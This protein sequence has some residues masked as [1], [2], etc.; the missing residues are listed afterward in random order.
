MKM[1]FNE[2]LSWEK[3]KINFHTSH[4]ALPHPCYLTHLW[5]SA[6][7]H[8]NHFSS[9]CST[10]LLVSVCLLSFPCSFH[11]RLPQWLIQKTLDIIAEICFRFSSMYLI[12]NDLFSR[13]QKLSSLEAAF[14]KWRKKFYLIHQ[15]F[16]L[17]NPH[18]KE[19]FFYRITAWIRQC[20]EQKQNKLTIIT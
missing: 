8:E 11:W 5:A 20:L 14:L 15:L 12:E 10:R 4:A 7:T 17:M 18:T 9:D 19:T 2:A 6:Y 16:F 13:F 1:F 3:Q